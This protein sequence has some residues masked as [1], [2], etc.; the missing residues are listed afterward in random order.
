MV[1][2][3]LAADRSPSGSSPRAIRSVITQSHPDLTTLSAA[4]RRHELVAV[5]DSIAAATGCAR[6]WPLWPPCRRGIVL[7][8][9]VQPATVDALPAVV[10]RLDTQD[11]VRVTVGQLLPTA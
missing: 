6:G 1:G 3:Q 10:A 4:G 5:G 9:D 2:D 8:R 11:Y 7:L